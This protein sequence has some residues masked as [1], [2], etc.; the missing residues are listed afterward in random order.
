MNKFDSYII[1]FIG[2]VNVVIAIWVIDKITDNASDIRHLHDTKADKIA[3]ITPS[4]YAGV[5]GEKSEIVGELFIEF[6]K[7]IGIKEEE[8]DPFRV[9]AV[10]KL[11][12]GVKLGTTRGK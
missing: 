6:G 2:A 3:V 5:E 1:R 4:L 7:I 11:N 8:L 10:K 12:R 9:K